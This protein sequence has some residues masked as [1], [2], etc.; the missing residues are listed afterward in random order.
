[1]AARPPVQTPPPEQEMLTVSWLSKRPEVLDRLLRGG[2]NPRVALNY[3]AP[4]HPQTRIQGCT[5]P[6]RRLNYGAADQ[7]VSLT[8]LLARRTGPRARSTH[9]LR[10]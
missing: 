5:H 8:H 4:A 9:T 1:M 7:S 2:E 10:T 3:G 6:P